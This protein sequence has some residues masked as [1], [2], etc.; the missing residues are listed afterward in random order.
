[1]FNIHLTIIKNRNT[2][3]YLVKIFFQKS[4]FILVLSS[5]FFSALSQNFDTLIDI[6][7]K[8]IYKVVKIGNQSWMGENLRYEA[9]TGS[10][11]YNG[12]DSLSKIYGRLYN[13]ETAKLSCPE[14]WHLPSDS[15][16][17]ILEMNL[18]MDTIYV[19]KRYNRD[20]R[21]NIGGK[22]KSTSILWKHSNKGATDESGFSVLPSGILIPLPFSNKYDYL[23]E[24]AFFWT[25]SQEENSCTLKQKGN[26]FIWTRILNQKNGKIDREYMSKDFGYSVRCMKD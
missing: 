10:W 4:L 15:E 5:I 17:E 18:G 7:D 8:Q 16:W 21:A 26:I 1:M 3:L 13:W 2:F 25:S 23:G 14:G 9:K 12:N 19:D 11:C 22:L 6:R 20:K 24:F